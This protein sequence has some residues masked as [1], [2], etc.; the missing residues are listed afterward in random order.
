[1]PA[2]RLEQRFDAVPDG[3]FVALVVV[4]AYCQPSGAGDDGECRTGR[5]DTADPD[6]DTRERRDLVCGERHL[7]DIWNP[8]RVGDEIQPLAVRCP[9]RVHLLAGVE[10]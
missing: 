7:I 5:R 2:T 6:P 1:M 8:V 4:S 3:N 9:L 10:G